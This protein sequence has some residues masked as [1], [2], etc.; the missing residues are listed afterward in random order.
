MNPI[1]QRLSQSPQQSGRSSNVSALIE[2]LK[3]G[4]VN[5]KDEALKMVA[6]ASP[7]MKAKLRVALPMLNTLAKKYGISDSEINSFSNALQE[8]L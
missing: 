1:F 5:A 2:G 4:S 6:S 3:N 7:Q 8:K